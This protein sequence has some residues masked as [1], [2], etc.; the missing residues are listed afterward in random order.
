MFNVVLPGRQCGPDKALGLLRASKGD[1][2]QL[3]RVLAI[4]W[5]RY[6][7]QVNAIAHTFIEGPFTANRSFSFLGHFELLFGLF[8]DGSDGFTNVFG[9]RLRLVGL[10]NLPRFL[11]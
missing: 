9:E 5:A 6:S 4:K 2:N 1:L 8:D 11:P 7:I 3:T 10:K